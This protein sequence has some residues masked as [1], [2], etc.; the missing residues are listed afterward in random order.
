MRPA[1][2]AAARTARPCGIVLW[3]APPPWPLGSLTAAA[4]AHGVGSCIMGAID[5][6][7]LTKL[8]GLPE[9]LR[10]CY[11]VALGYPTHESHLVE[12]RDGSVKYY[13]DE[14]RNYCVPKRGMEEV[15][16]K[17]L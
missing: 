6:P 1:L 15:L 16:I 17:T 3:K 9:G 10:L 4:W 11:M 2:P 12:I 7:A 8:L 13:L 14:N 5:R